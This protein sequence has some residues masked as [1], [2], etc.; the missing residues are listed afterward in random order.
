M[1]LTRELR[2]SLQLFF[3]V[4]GDLDPLLLRILVDAVESLLL[5][6]EDELLRV[7]RLLGGQDGEEIPTK[8]RLIR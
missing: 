7:F 6:V 5:A 8:T 3:P 1:P 4:V 2:E